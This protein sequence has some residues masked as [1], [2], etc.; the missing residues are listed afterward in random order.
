MFGFFILKNLQL[1]NSYP[2][3]LI[4]NEFEKLV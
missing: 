3:Y 4:N 1:L 2:N